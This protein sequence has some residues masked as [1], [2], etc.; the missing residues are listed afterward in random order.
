MRLRVP[1]GLLYTKGADSLVRTRDKMVQN[2]EQATTGK[3]INR[4]SDDPVGIMKVIDLKAKDAR[5]EAIQMNLETANGFLNIADTSLGELSEVLSRT[6]E[7]AL[8][9]SNSTNFG[10][11]VRESVSKEVEQLLM[12]AVQI[13]NTRVGDRYIFAGYQTNR[14]PFD[15]NGNY[16]GDTGEIHVELGRG[17]TMAINVPGVQPFFGISEV[18]QESESIRQDPSQNSLPTVSGDLRT[19][20]S[21]EASNRDVDQDSPEYADIARRS[22]VNVFHAIRNFASALHQG[23]KVEVNAT[24]DSLDQAFKQVLSSRSIVG[25][26][27]NMLGLSQSSLE[28][29]RSNSASLKSAAEDADVLKMYS[30]L[31]KNENVLKAS[32]EVNRKILSPSLLDFLK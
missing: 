24:I 15:P 11:D 12:R 19:P 30:D 21:V 9:M 7:L 1:D 3:R 14:P 8:Q 27:Q 4:P 6:K 22:G 32:L 31:G 28:S 25:A 5:E 18:P 16:F 20:A 2:Q 17:Q 29:S 10:G 23:N 26:R 13:G